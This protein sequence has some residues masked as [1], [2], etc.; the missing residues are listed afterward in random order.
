MRNLGQPQ[1]LSQVRPFGHERDDAA[2]VGLEKDHQDQQGKELLLREILAAVPA[3]IGGKG[4]LRDLH[5]LPGQRHR[6]PRHRSC[7][8]HENCIESMNS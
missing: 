6:R 8:F 7:G 5:G 2:M 1:D 4:P 3:G